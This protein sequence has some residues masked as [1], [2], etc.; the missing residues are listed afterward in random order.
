MRSPR[1]SRGT[2]SQ[3]HRNPDGS[4]TIDHLL[5]KQKPTPSTVNG[6]EASWDGGSWKVRRAK[7]RKYFNDQQKAVRAFDI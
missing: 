7:P 3:S 4:L 6:E 2:D 1:L 5:R